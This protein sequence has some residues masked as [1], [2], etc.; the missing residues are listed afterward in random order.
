V[1]LGAG[2]RFEGESGFTREELVR[3]SG[4]L[5]GGL[6]LSGGLRRLFAG[7]AALA[8]PPPPTANGAVHH[9]L[10]RPDLRPP[11]LDVLRADRVSDGYLFLAPSAGPGQRGVLIVDDR[12][13][14][15][16]FHPTTPN[17]AMNFRVARYHGKPVLTWWEGKSENGLGRG[18][19]VILDQSYR[20][21]ARVRAGEGRQSDLH[22]FVITPHNS[23]LVTSYEVRPADLSS[24]GGPVS[25][26]VIGGV[27]QELALPRGRVLFEWRSLDHVPIEETHAAFQGHP[28]DYFHVNSIDLLADG[29]LLVS[30][31][32]TWAAYKVSRASGRVIW[33]LGGKRS[34]FTMGRGTVFAWQHDAR[35]HGSGLVTIFDDGAAPQ[36]EP[37]SRVLVIRLDLENKRATLVRSYRHHPNRLV[38]QF[39]G[40][41]QMLPN[42]NVVVGWGNEPYVT[43]FG[44]NGEI[45]FDAKLPRG[46][47]NYRAFRFD[48]SGHPTTDPALAARSGRHARAVYASWNGATEVVAWRLRAGAAA[49]VVE[50]IGV[51]QKH[52]FETRLEV[53]DGL[54][55]AT[56]IALDRHG[57]E[58]G[59]SHTISRLERAQQLGERS[60]RVDDD[61]GALAKFRR[62]LW[63]RDR[64]PDGELEAVEGGEPVEVGRVVTGIQRA[65]EARLV[66]Q[67]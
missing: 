7:D 58:L 66:E 33:R 31:R 49:G 61:V 64:D 60:G 37:Q 50:T 51:T 17:T 22:E 13:E 62:P 28:L 56:A 47:M 4:L 45:L 14:V 34:D 57:H 54:R 48:W 39:M 25:G 42:G 27:V 53:P 32:N 36:V 1:D 6:L 2:G 15:V 12:G 63:R 38:S 11:V 41:A 21:L 26:K 19:H 10:S 24:V 46:S 5:G 43:E 35:H 18:T 65:A 23:A 52:G 30:A 9:F 16:F 40:N 3:R 29:N 44:S 8:A 59:R 20:E 67:A 55:F